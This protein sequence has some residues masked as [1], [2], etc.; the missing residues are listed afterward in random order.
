MPALDFDGSLFNIEFFVPAD[1]TAKIVEVN[2]RMASQFAPSFAPC[3]GR[4]R[5]GSSSSW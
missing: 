1:G 3:T 5:T 2:G 4:R